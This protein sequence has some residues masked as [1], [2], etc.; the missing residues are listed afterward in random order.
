MLS[1]ISCLTT[2]GISTLKTKDKYSVSL[3]PKVGIHMDCVVTGSKILLTYQG[4]T[5]A[6]LQTKN[7]RNTFEVVS[8]ERSIVS[9]PSNSIDSF[10]VFDFYPIIDALGFNWVHRPDGILVCDQFPSEL[11]G[12]IQQ[13]GYRAYGVAL[14]HTD[15]DVG[16]IASVLIR[17]GDTLGVV[18]TNE[19]QACT[20]HLHLIDISKHT[21]VEIAKLL[22]SSTNVLPKL[23]TIAKTH[24][25]KQYSPNHDD[26]LKDWE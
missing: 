13:Y 6:K 9:Y 11:F 16:V 8:E 7:T 22:Y 26:Y 17:V 15:T 20:L 24:K 4:I 25:S 1:H 23:H 19:V 18:V 2:S 3:L 21:P 14:A 5:V 12:G 10:A